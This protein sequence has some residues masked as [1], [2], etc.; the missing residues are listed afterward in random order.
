MESKHLKFAPGEVVFEEGDSNTGIY[1]IQE[2]E[3]EVYRTRDGFEV[4]LGKLK[5]GDFI[6]TV[7]LLSGDSRSASV[8]SLTTSSVI[9]YSNKSIS[10]VFKSIPLWAQAI[11]K[12]AIARLKYV[13]EILIES[14][15]NENRLQ[16]KCL[17][18][19]Q[20]SAQVAYLIATLTKTNTVKVGGKNVLP[21]QGF[22]SHCEKIF[23]QKASY[24]E[25]IL[26]SFQSS[27]LIEVESFKE[28]GEVILNP[29]TEF[30]EDYWLHI[31]NLPAELQR[32]NFVKIHHWFMA[33]IRIQKK[34]PTISHFSYNELCAALEKELGKNDV[35]KV[36]DE[37]I[38]MS[39]VAENPENKKLSYQIKDL[40]KKLIFEKILDILK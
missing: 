15:I 32:K 39:V 36:V 8:R 3:F 26:K 10:D 37:L 13:N 33:L 38:A 11:S 29:N 14:K 31:K 22:L 24:L 12:D 28:V 2:G 16:Q 25:K 1:L 17:T 19:Y 30:L 9:L 6:G 40:E 4:H 34:H 18:T 20:H 23:F 35:Q 7:T 27:G 5:N 21:I